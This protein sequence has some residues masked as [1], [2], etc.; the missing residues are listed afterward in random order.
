[1]DRPRSR[2]NLCGRT[3]KK[4]GLGCWVTSHHY[5]TGQR[6]K[7]WQVCHLWTK[8]LLTIF[9]CGP[10]AQCGIWKSGAQRPRLSSPEVMWMLGTGWMLLEW[11]AH[12]MLSIFLATSTELRRTGSVL[13]IND[14]HHWEIVWVS[15]W[16]KL[17]RRWSHHRVETLLRSW[18]WWWDEGRWQE[19]SGVSWWFQ[20]LCL[21]LMHGFCS[22][23]VRGSS[24]TNDV[25][26]EILNGC[27]EKK[28][29]KNHENG[30]ALN[31]FQPWLRGRCNGWRLNKVRLIRSMHIFLR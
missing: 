20:F 8:P 15:K 1:M 7:L 16:G 27:L 2:D 13:G 12:H 14:H 10:V 31:H 25:V 9:S 24:T 17:Q 29:C 26:R 5:C 28:S 30:L 6:K 21:G 23:Q 18:W 19:T 11:C 4:C 3:P 22:L